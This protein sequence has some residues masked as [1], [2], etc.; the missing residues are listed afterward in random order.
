MINSLKAFFVLISTIIGLG[1]FML[2]Y[3]F[4]NSGYVFFIWMFLIVIVM[5]LIHLMIGEILLQTSA[6]HNL[7]SLAAI[8]LSPKLKNIVWFNDYLGML[9]IFFIYLIVL[10]KL[11]SSILPVDAIYIKL[12]FVLLNIIFLVKNFLIFSR[13][14]SVLSLLIIA[15]FIILAAVMFNHFNFNNL[16]Y[17]FFN[18][19]NFWLP[20]GI[21]IFA[22]SGNS[23]LPLVYDL[24]GKDKKKFFYVNLIA[25]LVVA[26]LYLLYTIAVVGF[27]G[28]N[29]SEESLNSLRDYLGDVFFVLAVLLVTLNI[30]F[31][32]MAFYL[33]RGL[34]YDY[35]LSPTKANIFLSLCILSLIFIDSSQ[36]VFLANVVS[37]LFV[38]FNFFIICLIYLKLKQKLYFNLSKIIIFLLMTIF[39]SG[40]CYSLYSILIN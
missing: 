21:M 2:P 13:F 38:G 14:E 11:W 9:G 28:I 6:K 3:V 4:V 15:L 30:T 18:I 22:F 40:I 27:L 33:K 35:S 36:I 32:D 25:L 8:Y 31:V 16:Y 24:V 37:S 29:V 1:V 34:I 20:Y 5:F 19:Q 7:P 23:A 10:G 12:V 26:F 17:S 39:L